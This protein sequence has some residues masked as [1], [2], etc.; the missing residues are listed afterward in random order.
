MPSVKT[1]DEDALSTR[2]RR[3]HLPWRIARMN[4]RE[5]RSGSKKRRTT[6]KKE[7][8]K[9]SPPELQSSSSFHES[10]GISS[11]TSPRTPAQ[12]IA[13]G[14]ARGKKKKVE[15]KRNTSSPACWSSVA[16]WTSSDSSAERFRATARLPGRERKEQKGRGKKKKK[17][18]RKNKEANENRT[19]HRGCTQVHPSRFHRSA[20]FRIC[21]K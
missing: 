7:N 11:G 6:K 20:P 3:R 4:A 5:K 18:K 17:R 13:R 12:Q 21:G 19:K 1:C 15:R 9:K 2:R 10:A 16:S 8:M 14:E